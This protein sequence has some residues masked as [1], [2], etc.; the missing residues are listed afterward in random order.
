MIVHYCKVARHVDGRSLSMVVG[1]QP[2]APSAFG[3]PL[4]EGRW[5]GSIKQSQHPTGFSVSFGHRNCVMLRDSAIGTISRFAVNALNHEVLR[6]VCA[7]S[8][9]AQSGFDPRMRCQ[10]SFHW[11][12]LVTATSSDHGCC[13]LRAS[14]GLAHCRRYGK[15]N[16]VATSPY[17]TAS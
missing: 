8:R 16:G 10:S 3:C 2:A 11:L 5:P 4:R 12:D 1:D 13:R 7:K 9:S 17:T 6:R 14:A 15:A